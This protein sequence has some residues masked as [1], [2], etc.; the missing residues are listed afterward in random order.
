MAPTTQPGPP[1]IEVSY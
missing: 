1:W